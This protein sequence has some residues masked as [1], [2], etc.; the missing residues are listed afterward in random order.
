MDSESSADLGLPISPGRLEDIF[1]GFFVS[2]ILFGICISQAWTYIN[3]NSDSW[4]IRVWVAALLIGNLAHTIIVLQ[5]SHYYLIPHSGIAM[6]L[7][8]PKILL[9]TEWM[10]S[11]VI[12]IGA[13]LYFAR[14][15]YLFRRTIW[16]PAVI[17]F[18]C[19]ASLVTTSYGIA[20]PVVDNWALPPLGVRVEILA[21]HA[22]AV[23]VDIA[24]T[25]GMWNMFSPKNYLALRTRTVAEKLIIYAAARGLLLALAQVMHLISVVMKPRD[26]ISWLPT[27]V[28]LSHLCISTLLAIL[29]ARIAFRETLESDCPP[30]ISLRF[31]TSSQ[32]LTLRSQDQEDIRTAV[33]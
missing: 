18:L 26:I 3:N 33:V 28:V 15:I 11:G 32:T 31:A 12:Q 13:Q 4:A 25:V 27:Q 23:F 14:A 30:T 17:V 16:L 5:V 9:A 7:A 22:A 21:F 24:T 10:L 1:Y 29:N 8:S 20:H 2:T 19:A 6:I